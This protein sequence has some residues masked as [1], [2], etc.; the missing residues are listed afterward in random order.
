MN[1]QCLNFCYTQQKYSPYRQGHPSAIQLTPKPA[2]MCYFSLDSAACS[3]AYFVSP[4]QEDLLGKAI[5]AENP[6][7]HNPCFVVVTSD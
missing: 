4:T 2:H 7:L 3:Y 1:T 6:P 5:A